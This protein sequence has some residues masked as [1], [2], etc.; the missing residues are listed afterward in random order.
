M[1]RRKFTWFLWLTCSLLPLAQLNAFTTAD[2]AQFQQ[3][4]HQH[5]RGK[6]AKF[7]Q[8][9]TLQEASLLGRFRSVNRELRNRGGDFRPPGGFFDAEPDSY[10]VRSDFDEQLINSINLPRRVEAWMQRQRRV[11]EAKSLK[12]DNNKQILID[13]ATNDQQL[14]MFRFD[15]EMAVYTYAAGNHELAI[16]QLEDII[17]FYSYANLDDVYFML[18]EANYAALR[19]DAAREIYLYLLR[20]YPSN[21]WLGPIVDHLVY[22]W[23]GYSDFAAITD[24]YATYGPV[25][26]ALEETWRSEVLYMVGVSFFQREG[27]EQARELLL[28]T[29][30]DYNLRSRHLLATCS[31]FLDDSEQALQLLGEL[32]D[33]PIRRD[34]TQL[35]RYI[36]DDANIKLGYLHFERGEFHA[37]FEAFDRVTLDSELADNAVLGRAWADLNVQDYD[38]AI[39]YANELIDIY[40]AS[41]FIFEA[42]V[43]VGHAYELIDLQ[44]N[45]VPFYSHVLEEGERFQ[46]MQEYTDERRR[47]V[48]E[49]KRLRQLEADVFNEEDLAGYQQYLELDH[50]LDILYQRI[51]YLLLMEANEVMREYISERIAI[52]RLQ[53]RLNELVDP[54][55]ATQ[56]PEVLA[57]V[58]ELR[59]TGKELNQRIRLSGI[60]EIN[61]NPIVQVEN[62]TAYRQSIFRDLRG[63]IAAEQRLLEATLAESEQL[64]ATARLGGVLADQIETQ[65]THDVLSDL[66]AV[67]DR[68]ETRLHVERREPVTSDI[69]RW[70]DVS[71]SRLALGKIQF[72]QLLEMDERMQEIEGYLG[73][74]DQL[75]EE[76]E[77]AIEE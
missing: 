33:I 20:T 54:A 21:P 46:R 75:L 62:E 47:I 2:S 14:R 67:L 69:N 58:E 48:I 18:A 11:L 19:Y 23:F 28:E 17:R 15:L 40:P 26:L 1:I 24:F 27:Y 6:I 9:L 63:E 30:G 53:R 60:I 74:I 3:E 49:L 52:Q 66:Q 55:L 64:V 5:F 44:D 73:A 36:R 77:G 13:S 10:V 41:R 71:F 50:D 12:V 61:K 59:R 45:S 29:R 22:T 72:N 51:R 70:S 42:Y 37:A 32:G 57:T 68:Y 76:T 7:N 35:D 25:C 34:H 8:E 39:E 4:L 16:L 38:S 65:V 31:I 56:D 43:L